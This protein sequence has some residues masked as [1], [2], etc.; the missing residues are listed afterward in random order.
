[1]GTAPKKY[2]PLLSQ[3]HFPLQLLPV[4]IPPQEAQGDRDGGMFVCW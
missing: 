2:L 4:Q 1:M 3:A